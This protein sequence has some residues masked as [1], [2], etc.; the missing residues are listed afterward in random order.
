[1]RGARGRGAQPC[2][3]PRSQCASVSTRWSCPP[4]P[5]SSPSPHA[6]YCRY[7]LY[8][9]AYTS[10]DGR[11]QNKLYFILWAPDD[12]PSLSKMKY[13]SHKSAATKSM[14]GVFDI[15]CTCQREVEL[16]LGLVKEEAEES[17]DPGHR[18]C[19]VCFS[20][21]Y[22]VPL[23]SLVVSLSPQMREH[24]LRSPAQCHTGH[25]FPSDRGS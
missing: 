1:M 14:P 21:V 22:L 15:R 13:S 6:L 19:V 7:V 11:P 12:S 16:A 20:R 4:P 25:A 18:L 5:F 2:A 10:P 24:C 3:S 23:C 17:W 9:H 8:D